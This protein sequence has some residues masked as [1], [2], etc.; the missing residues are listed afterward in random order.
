MSGREKKHLSHTEHAG[1]TEEKNK[2][3]FL[4][5]STLRTTQTLSFLSSKA[6]TYVR[7]PDQAGRGLRWSLGGGKNK[8]AYISFQ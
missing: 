1:I 4:K 5:E 6:L 7:S 2:M 3:R 8:L